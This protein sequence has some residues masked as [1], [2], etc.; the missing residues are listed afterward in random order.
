MRRS[1]SDTLLGFGIVLFT[2]A[3]VFAFLGLTL[4]TTIAMVNLVAFV[5]DV[6]FFKGLAE[7]DNLL[8]SYLGGSTFLFLPTALS[9]LSI[10]VIEDIE[11][12]TGDCKGAFKHCQ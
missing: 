2:V 11:N 1:P 7:M 3:G 6:E 9:T 10:E 4:A 12:L 5:T 8:V